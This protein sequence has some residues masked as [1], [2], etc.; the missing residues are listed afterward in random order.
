MKWLS[1]P[2]LIASALVLSAAV[3]PRPSPPLITEQRKGQSADHKN[4]GAQEPTSLPSS[5][6]LATKPCQSTR[7]AN[8][9]QAQGSWWWPPLPSSWVLILITAAYA[10]ISF[11]TLGTISRQAD[12]AKSVLTHLE[13][14][15]VIVTP[16]QVE[17]A[18]IG[19]ASKG[20]WV[21]E[22]LNDPALKEPP[23]HALTFE[24]TIA[25]RGRSPAWICG[26]ISKALKIHAANLPRVP[27]YGGVGTW[28]P[29]PIA[30]NT[31]RPEKHRMFFS[32]KEF[33]AFLNGELDF[34]IVGLTKYKD[35]F[36]AEHETRFCL[37][38]EHPAGATH[39]YFGG[40][41]AYN[42]YT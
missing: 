14:A 9:Q 35:V 8:K 2:I 1:L 13:R 34:V 24:Y 27:D 39:T 19:D 12:L 10:V 16:K 21:Q 40:P 38:C 3:L 42:R 18:D 32:P 37:V 31:D 6:P 26:G 5:G 28:T 23:S 25:N 41:E 30:Q 4:I 20:R 17:I 33:Q 29:T 22:H 36:G 11:W 7:D 15:W